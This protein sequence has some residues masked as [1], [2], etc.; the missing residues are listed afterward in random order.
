LN[1]IP[2][3]IIGLLSQIFP[4]RYTQ[5]EIDALFLYSGA[6]EPV[7]DL[8]KPKKVQAWL[9]RTNQ[10]H[11][12]PIKVLG[13]ILDDF[14]EKSDASIGFWGTPTEDEEL[15]FEMEKEKVR[16]TLAR[17]GMSYNR[18][19]TILKSGSTSTLSLD[20]SV[21]R[22]GLESVEIEIKR[23]LA[24]I[25]DDPHAAAQYA[26]NVLEASLKAYLDA[27][28]KAYGSGDTLHDLWKSAVVEIGLRPVDL[29]NKDL[30]KIATGLKKSG[31]HGK[32][33]MQTR[34]FVVKP[35]HARLAIHSSHTVAAYVLELI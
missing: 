21:K 19:G 25:E 4:N 10:V 17:E 23:A 29:D 20:E 28:Q 13:Q 12:D 22:H 34:S 30:K 16:E 14:M 24:Q 35:R 2:T 7:P 15:K 1:S 9:R 27:K 5:A 33:E 26:G 8:S 31:A 18:G 6:P 32:S 3:S 11:G